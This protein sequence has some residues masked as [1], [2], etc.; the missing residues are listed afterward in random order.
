MEPGGEDSMAHRKAAFN[1]LRLQLPS[2]MISYLFKTW[3][4]FL[5]QSLM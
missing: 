5:R 2:D 4:Y 1:E 3:P